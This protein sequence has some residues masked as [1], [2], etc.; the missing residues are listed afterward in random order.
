MGPDIAL[1]ASAREWPDRLHRFLLDHGGGRIVDRV[2]TPDQASDAGFDVLL[3]DDVCSFLTPR[4][5]TM[6]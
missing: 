2:M 5:V 3:I 4:L 1:A 6:L